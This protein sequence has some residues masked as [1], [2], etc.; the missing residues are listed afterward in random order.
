MCKA[1]KTLTMAIVLAVIAHLVVA[2]VLPV[3]KKFIVPLA[4]PPVMILALL[5]AE[6]SVVFPSVLSG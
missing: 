4:M 6:H 3:K 5:F 1:I 2:H